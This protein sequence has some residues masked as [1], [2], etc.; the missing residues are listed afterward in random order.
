MAQNKEEFPLALPVTF[1]TSGPSVTSIHTN[2]ANYA[3]KVSDFYVELVENDAGLLAKDIVLDLSSIRSGAVK[4]ADACKKESSNWI[5]VWKNI[6]ADAADGE[7]TVTVSGTDVLGNALTGTLSAKI[8]LDRTPPVI[9]KLE[10]EPLGT[11]GQVALPGGYYKT[12]DAVGINIEAKEI[13]D[14]RAYIDLSPYLSSGK[15][16]SIGCKN[17]YQDKWICSENSPGIDIPGHIVSQAKITLSDA[18]GN[19]VEVK[20]NLEVFAYNDAKN[21]SHWKPIVACSPSLV[22]RQ[23]AEMVNTR[24]YCAVE[25]L[26][27]EQDQETLLMTLGTC[28][29]NINGSLSYLEKEPELLNDEKGSTEPF[30]AID[31]AQQ[32]MKVDGFS[33]TCPLEIVS[34]IGPVIT[35]VKEVKEIDIDLQFYN[36]PLGEYGEGVQKLIEDAKDDAENTLWKIIGFM[37]LILKWAEL[38][39]NALRI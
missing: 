19:T 23:V 22:D 30:L 29:E 3:A 1:D 4:A 21:I 31:L 18:A 5:C 11:G 2:N 16:I 34:R 12:G 8:M 14:L 26:P 35:S 28:T 39:C 9:E 20:K 15:N 13:N 37:K 17:P 25:L 10:F 24:V 33:I 36:M 27:M 7:K 38:I 6:Q 32:K